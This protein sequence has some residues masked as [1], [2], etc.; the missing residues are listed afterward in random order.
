MPPCTEQI[1]M[2]LEYSPKVKAPHRRVTRFME[3]LKAKPGTLGL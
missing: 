2:D 3:E 1:A